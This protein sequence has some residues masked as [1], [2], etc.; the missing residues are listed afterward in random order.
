M[1]PLFWNES[2]IFVT[3]SLSKRAAADV[4]ASTGSA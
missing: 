2:N 1:Q 4:R 3:L